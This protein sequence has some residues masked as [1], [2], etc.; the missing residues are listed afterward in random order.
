MVSEG[1]LMDLRLIEPG[2]RVNPLITGLYRAI[3]TDTNL[4][5]Y[6]HVDTH[7]QSYLSL[8]ADKERGRL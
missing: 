1:W 8:Q 2:P 7:A 6:A 3:Y 4:G 5:M